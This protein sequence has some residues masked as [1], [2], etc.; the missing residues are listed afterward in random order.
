MTDYQFAYPTS[1]NNPDFLSA[2]PRFEILYIHA[3]GLLLQGD[4]EHHAIAR[5]GAAR[6]A[7]VECGPV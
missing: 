2:P 1:T 6:V 5:R 3:R 7:T 4:A